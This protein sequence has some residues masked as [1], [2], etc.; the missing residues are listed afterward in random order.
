MSDIRIAVHNTSPTGGTFLTPFWF[1]AHDRGFDVFDIGAASSAGLEALAEDGNFDPI[2]AE[3]AAFDADATMGAV[4]GA[5]G[6]IATAER[7]AL[8]TSIDGSQNAYI[9]LAAMILPSNDAFVATEDA[10]KLFDDA[11]AFK[12]VRNITFEGSD[13]LDAGT[14]VNTE[15]DAAFINQMGPNTGEDEGGVVTLHEG[16]LAEGEGT[17][18]GG[19]NAPGAFIDPVIADFTREG[20]GIAKVHINEYVESTLSTDNDL[21]QGNRVDDIVAAGDGHDVVYGRVGWDVIDGGNGNDVLFGGIGWDDLSGGDGAD[22]LYGGGGRDHLD[23]G[24]GLDFLYGGFGQDVLEGGEGE[25]RLFG[26]R[27]DD[28][29]DGGAGDDRVRGGSGA[30]TFV[31]AD[32]YSRDVVFAFDVEEDHVALDIEGIESFE[33]LSAFTREFDNRTVLNFGDGDVLVL[34][35]V[36]LDE[37]TADN[38]LLA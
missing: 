16:F 32:G 27:G 15:V 8:T 33:D 23:G 36:E 28:T 30:D 4:T 14:E 11:G 12:G 24:T 35:G 21:F 5:A 25:D 6:P 26:G 1:A 19:T 7:T 20:A 22:K 2:N 17:I 34:R 3:V 29:L 31:F 9:S 10:V 18:L 38:F 13:V 37:L